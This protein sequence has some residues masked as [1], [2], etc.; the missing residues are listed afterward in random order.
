LE[1]DLVKI[2]II[3]LLSFIQK[4]VGYWLAG[5]LTGWTTDSEVTVDE[6][7]QRLTYCKLKSVALYTTL[8]CHKNV[9]K[10]IYCNVLK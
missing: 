3:L 10:T 7:Q 2:V 1:L 9:R 4:P 6:K 8:L 5:W